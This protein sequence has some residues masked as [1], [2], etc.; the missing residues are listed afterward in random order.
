MPD[1]RRGVRRPPH[2]CR[3]VLACAIALAAVPAA[4]HAQ[5][6][7]EGVLH[8]VWE[9]PRSATTAPPP[10][11]FLGDAAG[12]IRLDVDPVLAE[13]GGWR[14]L[15]G[16]AVRVR[17]VAYTESGAGGRAAR[18]L[19]VHSL[20]P[21]AG[22][23][24]RAAAAGAAIPALAGPQPYATVLCRATDEAAVPHPASWYVEAVLGAGYPS[25]RDYWHEASG[26]RISLAGSAVY[27]W[28][29]LGHPR[30][31]YWLQGDSTRW[32]LPRLAGDCA[33]AAGGA[34]DF[35]AFSGVNF[36]FA[37]PMPAS[38]GGTSTIVLDGAPRAIRTTWLA[39]WAGRWA[40][41]HEMAHTFGLPHSSGPY[42]ATYDSQWDLM[43]GYLHYDPVLVDWIPQHTIAPYKEKLGWIGQERRHVPAAGSRTSLA[44]GPSVLPHDD[45]GALLIEVPLAGEPG[46]RYT[47]EARRGAGY[48]AALPAAGVIL[49]R[50]DEDCFGSLNRACAKVVDVD[51]D[52]DPNDQGALFTA[53]ESFADTL[54]GVAFSIDAESAWGWTVTVTRGWPLT[55]SPS[56]GGRIVSL[57]A[58]IDCAVGACT[59][60]LPTAGPLQLTAFPA[61]GWA[62]A[63]WA[64]DCAGTNPV[65]TLAVGSAHEVAARFVATGP[66][67]AIQG[68]GTGSGRITGPGGIACEVSGGAA[69]GTCRAAFD[70]D[71][72]IVLTATAQP[73]SAFA[74]WSGA[75]V[76]SGTTCVARMAAA[77]AIRATFA[78][79]AVTPPGLT[80]GRIVDAVLG[81]A[82]LSAEEA[83]VVDAVGNRNGGLD[84]GD[85]V[86]WRRTIE[87]ASAAR[88]PAR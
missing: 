65:C 66:T 15:D 70:P 43:S 35:A 45:D 18:A 30:S 1:T 24:D 69:T 11:F 52:G 23:A 78:P 68:D 20:D 22:P 5:D 76:P 59:T 2:A 58:G 10:L 12:M 33:A 61:D 38:F 28:F 63:E 82:A 13:A 53:G 44:L 31:A 50:V 41:A 73:G 40:Y 36:Q 86:A 62:F 87:A 55:V 75:C 16:R 77:R 7:A 74:G 71:A 17:G 48:D 56:E 42:A 3:L 85:V 32:D 79:G 83:D 14:A 60:I 37:F 49:H 9:D 27:G 19:R 46:V 84:L 6:A 25:T 80:A 34:V 4:A 26:G 54:N 72:L 39:G 29:E 67:L 64:G 51:G 21:A 81:R 57:P 88:E 47:L 8:V